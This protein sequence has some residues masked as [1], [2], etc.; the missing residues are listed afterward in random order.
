M[1]DIADLRHYSISLQQV[2]ANGRASTLKQ[3]ESGGFGFLTQYGHLPIKF[4]GQEPN[5]STRAQK[6]KTL[7]RRQDSAFKAIRCLSKL[8]C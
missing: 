3:Y 4:P 8:F 7:P 5:P 6:V 1:N 2:K